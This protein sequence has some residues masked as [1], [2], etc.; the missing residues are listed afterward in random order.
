MWPFSSSR[1]LDEVRAAELLERE[2][3]RDDITQV[4]ISLSPLMLKGPNV[5]INSHGDFKAYLTAEY[6]HGSVD[7]VI[8]EMDDG[9]WELD[10][11]GLL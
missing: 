2:V 4:R 3:D 7:Y 8:G 6:Q 10:Y 1:E 9:E 11:D 5:K